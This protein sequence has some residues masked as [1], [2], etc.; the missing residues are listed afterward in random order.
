MRGRVLTK[1]KQCLA[2]RSCQMACVLAH[3]S[4][5]DLLQAIAEQSHSPPRV[6][7]VDKDGSVAILR[8]QHC[9]NPKCVEACPTGA[10]YQTEDGMVLLN[11]EACEACG[12]C[13]EA[14]PFDAIWMLPDGSC[15]YKCDLCI[16]RLERGELPAC[17]E[18]CPTGALT[19]RPQKAKTEATE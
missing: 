13:V 15:V 17:V 3:S 19:F 8:C 16:E 11:P 7:I 6:K 2:C 12:A 1:A 14:C 9:R 4:A 5:G 10:L 18:A